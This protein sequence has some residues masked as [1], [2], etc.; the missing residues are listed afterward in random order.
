MRLQLRNNNNKG[1]AG[2]TKAGSNSNSSKLQHMFMHEN[3]V[4][5]CE[6]MYALFT[7][8]FS[9][10]NGSMPLAGCSILFAAQSFAAMA[11]V[12]LKQKQ[13]Q[14]TFLCWLPYCLL[15]LFSPCS[16]AYY[17]CLGIFLLWS[18]NSLTHRNFSSLLI[19]KRTIFMSVAGVNR[20][21]PPLKWPSRW[22]Y[23]RFL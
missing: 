20:S 2:L 12:F 11:I 17:Y 4:Y 8:N 22:T 16:F 21:D 1:N 6:V 15:L 18:E 14:Q 10:T 23:G 7:Y 13:E 9:D 19:Q 3:R 5:V